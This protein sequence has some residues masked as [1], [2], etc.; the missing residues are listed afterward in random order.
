MRRARR[1]FA[2]TGATVALAGARLAAVRA[3]AQHGRV[4]APRQEP[5][6]AAAGQPPVARPRGKR[7]LFW[8]LA[9]AVLA[10]LAAAAWVSLLQHTPD[11]RAVA[12]PLAAAPDAAEPAKPAAAPAGPL[13][14]LAPAT[15]QA[16][17]GDALLAALDEMLGRAAVQRFLQTGNFAQR[18]VATLDNLG[19]E[20]APVAMWP[21]VPTPG[22]FMVD[23]D[24]G[25]PHIAVANAA[26]YDAF[27]AF[28]SSLDAQAVVDLYRRFYP[29]LQQAYRDLGFGDR[30]LND[31]VIEV[32]DLLLATPQPGQAPEVTL[33][34]V[35]GPFA[36]AQ[37][38]TRYEYTDPQWQALSAGQKI[39]LRVGADNRAR[40]K[41][42][43]REIRARLRAAEA[44]PA[45]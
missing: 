36:A 39:L 5:T 24:T 15:A 7:R 40:L 12:P 4:N 38:W 31:R 11:I 18:V 33:T 25:T 16:V 13:H 42:K 35:K 3:W 23:E 27:V 19:R 44:P 30:Y 34:E 6:F 29:V 20:H 43:L 1:G 9:I 45:R 21:V 2:L 26:R 10:L 17:T 22:R 8:P 14:P 37:P 41:A 28:A 32:I